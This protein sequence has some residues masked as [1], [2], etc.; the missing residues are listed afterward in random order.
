[1]ANINS[2]DTPQ[3]HIEY[4]DFSIDLMD[5]LHDVQ[6]LLE[7]VHASEEVDNSLGRMVRMASERV[8]EVIDYLDKS[9]Y[10]YTERSEAV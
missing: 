6:A 7:T 10:T 1:M 3:K 4:F 5:R 8:Y 9:G 2:T